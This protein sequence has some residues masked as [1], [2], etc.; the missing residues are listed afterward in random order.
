MAADGVDAF[1]HVGPGNVTAGLAR[2]SAP[3]G[4][5]FTVSEIEDVASAVAFIE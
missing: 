4:E 1:I 2:R 3:D 5:A